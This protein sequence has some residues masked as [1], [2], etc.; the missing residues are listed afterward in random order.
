MEQQSDVPEAFSAFITRNDVQLKLF[1]C[2]HISVASLT[3]LFMYPVYFARTVVS[4]NP[5]LWMV[6]KQYSAT[7]D[8]SIIP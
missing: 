8:F 5:F 1:M 2:S 4:P 7:A 6:S 3:D